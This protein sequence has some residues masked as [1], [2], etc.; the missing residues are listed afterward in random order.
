MKVMTHIIL[1]FS[2]GLMAY[3]SGDTGV[4]ADRDLVIRREFH[5]KLAVLNIGGVTTTG[6]TEAAYVINELVMPNAVIA[7]H[8]NEAATRGGKLGRQVIA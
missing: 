8:A 7:S 6:P 3:L 5:A 2:N 1:R 4:I